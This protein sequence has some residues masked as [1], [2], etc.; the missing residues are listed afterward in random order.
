MD[1]PSHENDTGGESSVVEDIQDNE[2]SAVKDSLDNE[3]CAVD[4]IDNTLAVVDISEEEEEPRPHA[5]HHVF[6]DVVRMYPQRIAI[7]V[8]VGYL[9]ISLFLV[10]RF[11]I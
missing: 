1:N 11:L 6:E 7:E 2:P 4:G 8:R 10:L 5:L 3:P 9:C